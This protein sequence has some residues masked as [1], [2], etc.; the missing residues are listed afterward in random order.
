MGDDEMERL[1]YEATGE[2]GSPMFG[3][4][5]PSISAFVDKRMPKYCQG[6]GWVDTTR[7]K[8]VTM[9]KRDRSKDLTDFNWPKRFMKAAERGNARMFNL[10]IQGPNGANGP[11]GEC[12]VRNGG[13]C[14]SS[15]CTQGLRSAAQILVCGC[16]VIGRWQT[17]PSGWRWC[18]GKFGSFEGDTIVRELAAT[19]RFQK[20][21]ELLA[22]DECGSA[23]ASS[24]DVATT[25]EGILDLDDCEDIQPPSNWAK[26]TCEMQKANNCPTWLRDDTGFC[27]KTCGWC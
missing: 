4:D 14:C 5:W 25:V 23:S 26:N 19:I 24:G 1:T 13:R 22:T 8:G 7:K 18:N 21:K 3:S 12:P 10:N 9:G 11:E 2:S 15:A 27:K 16:K 6:D 20:V 17:D